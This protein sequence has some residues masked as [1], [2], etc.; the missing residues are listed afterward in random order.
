LNIFC[1][2]GCDVQE[3]SY[4]ILISS[5]QLDMTNAQVSNLL[6]EYLQNIEP[7]TEGLRIPLRSDCS[8][9]RIEDLTI[10]Q[11][12][13]LAEILKAVRMYCSGEDVSPQKVLRVTLCGEAG[14]GKSTWINTL[15]STMRKIFTEDETVAVYAPTGS[16][17]FNAGG[18]T[19]HRGFKVPVR[20]LKTM[21]IPSDKH[22]SL[23]FRYKRILILIIDE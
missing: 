12:E 21:E 13:P 2:A 8:E 7:V 4:I 22:K 18:E 1:D 10:D 9:Y 5:L 20:Q 23:L 17:A 19:V 14:S 3:V 16:A 11:K 6:N 15:V